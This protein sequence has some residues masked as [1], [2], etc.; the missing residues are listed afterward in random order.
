MKS[1]KLFHQ[2]I[3]SFSQNLQVLPHSLEA[4]QSLLGGLMLDNNYWDSIS[5]RIVADDFFTQSHKLIFKEMQYLLQSGHPID[6]ITLSESLEQ[7]GKLEIIGRFSYLAELS[8][9]TPSTAN[10][11]AYADIIKERSIF[12]EIILT[13]NKIIEK[14]YNPRGKTSEELLDYAES[15]VFKIS[16][17]K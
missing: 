6:L 15:S 1:N 5:D 8:K 9:N 2:K 16:E 11:T 10:I 17:K 13:A 3:N 7:K 12:R 4:E 14:S